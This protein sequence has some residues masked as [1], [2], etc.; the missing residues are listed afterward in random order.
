MA[1]T[2]AAELFVAYTALRSYQKVAERGAKTVKD[3]DLIQTIHSTDLLEFL[4]ADFPKP[5]PIEREIKA[6]VSIK[7]KTDLKNVN[8]GK[9]ILSFYQK[10]IQITRSNSENN[11]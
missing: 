6:K 2:K 5:K 1:I 4:K 7:N 8:D 9:N 10:P 11:E 3:T